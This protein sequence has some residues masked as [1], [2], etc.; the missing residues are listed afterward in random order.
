M[1]GV[2]YIKWPYIVS[3]ALVSIVANGVWCIVLYEPQTVVV[4][5]TIPDPSNTLH[6]DR[7][8]FEVLIA[9]KLSLVRMK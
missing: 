9:F 8:Q 4:R 2:F 6:T 3:E 7:I 1:D 5:N